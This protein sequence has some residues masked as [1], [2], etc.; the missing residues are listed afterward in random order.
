MGWRPQLRSGRP[1]E[2]FVVGLADLREWVALLETE[3]ALLKGK[4]AS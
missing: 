3:I 4:E 1:P 2:A